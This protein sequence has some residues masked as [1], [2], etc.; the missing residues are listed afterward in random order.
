MLGE[1]DRYISRK[2]GNMAKK[3]FQNLDF[4]LIKGANHFAQQHAPEETNRLIR[5]FIE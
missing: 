4:K 1:G 5:E 3:I 2:S